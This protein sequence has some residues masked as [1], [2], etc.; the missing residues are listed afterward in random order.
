M[1][2]FLF[3]EINKITGLSKNATSIY[4]YCYF[5]NNQDETNPLLA[6]I[7]SQLCRRAE[8]TPH[9]LRSIYRTR[10]RP[11]D[12]ELLEG[13]ENILNS[14]T[15]VNV[16]I[17]ALDESKKPY[18]TLLRTLKKLA[19]EP[20]FNKIQLLI[21]SRY[22]TDIRRVLSNFSDSVAMQLDKV[23]G[24]IRKHV[25]ELLQTELEFSG[26][27]EKLRCDVEERLAVGAEGM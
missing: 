22:L 23:E 5:G 26:W 18:T 1:A 10:I 12:D 25:T 3:N 7:V 2:S 15:C 9:N 27:P 19:T 21:T 4:Y 14:F 6:W 8:K 16:V 17:D 24:D 13:L 20:R 11:T